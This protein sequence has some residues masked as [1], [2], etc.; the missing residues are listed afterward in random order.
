MC[1]M[2][3][4]EV[5][6]HRRLN[7]QHSNY[8]ALSIFNTSYIKNINT[9]LVQEFIITVWIYFVKFATHFLLYYHTNIIL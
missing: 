6:G 4:R 9:I 3:C 7:T 8:R 5:I 1:C 2:L